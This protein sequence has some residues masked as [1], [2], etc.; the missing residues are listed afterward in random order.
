MHDFERKLNSLYDSSYKPLYRRLYAILLKVGRLDLQQEIDDCI[1]E[2]FLTLWQKRKE[3]QSHPN[4]NAWL[5]ITASYKLMNCISVNN[6]KAKHIVA[7]LDQ[8]AN[9][10][11]P[12]LKDY[13]S[14]LQHTK[15]SSV[16]QM[17]DDI[18]DLIDDE[19]F[20]FLIEYYDKQTTLKEMAAGHNTTEGA[21]KM[22][23]K[24]L[25]SRIKKLIVNAV[26]SFV[27]LLL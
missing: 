25:I 10:D 2:T 5:R 24:R 13:L 14:F 18:R 12:A 11:G 23:A 15:V 27:W 6:V 26:L 16:D 19:S 20:R 1:Q 21:L 22:K 3:L 9:D 17:L 4:I 8:N 7:S